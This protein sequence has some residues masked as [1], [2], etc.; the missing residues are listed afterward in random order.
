[1]ENGSLLMKADSF[2]VKMSN[3]LFIEGTCMLCYKT[4]KIHPSLSIRD[5]QKEKIVSSKQNDMQ[6]A[7]EIVM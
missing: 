3:Y 5:M 2:T 6:H 1:M 7:L 4:V